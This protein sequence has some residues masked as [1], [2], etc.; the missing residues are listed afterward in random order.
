MRGAHNGQRGSTDAGCFMN[1]S[2]HVKVMHFSL[3]AA[4]AKR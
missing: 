2:F 1:D 4:R 3:S